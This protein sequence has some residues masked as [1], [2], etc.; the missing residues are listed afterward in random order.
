M[1]PELKLSCS[2]SFIELQALMTKR[3]GMVAENIYLEHAGDMPIYG[4][5][6]FDII[7]E[8]MRALKEVNNG[9]V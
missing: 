9:D 8:K 6:N 4:K 1:F 7:A 2:D 5:Q 3:D